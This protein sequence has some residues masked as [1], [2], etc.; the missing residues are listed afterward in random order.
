MATFSIRLSRLA[1]HALCTLRAGGTWRRCS[2]I[3]HCARKLDDALPLFSPSFFEQKNDRQRS[4]TCENI[5]FSTFADLSTGPGRVRA[6]VRRP[7]PKGNID[8]LVPEIR[9]VGDGGGLRN[10]WSGLMRVPG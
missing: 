8:D 2:A 10:D 3:D 5:R 6:A 7:R 1:L 9:R 4:S